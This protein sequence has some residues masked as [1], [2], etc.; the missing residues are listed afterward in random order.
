MSKS[1]PCWGADG[2]KVGGELPWN[3]LSTPAFEQGQRHENSY[4]LGSE[5]TGTDRPQRSQRCSGA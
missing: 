5:V 1:V 2:A 3:Q 4:P